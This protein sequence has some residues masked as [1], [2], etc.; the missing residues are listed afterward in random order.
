VPRHARRALIVAATVAPA[1]AAAASA[2]AATD[3][4]TGA[5]AKTDAEWRAALEPNAYRVLRRAWT[6]PPFTRHV[7]SGARRMRQCCS[8]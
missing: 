8:L 5:I 4:R 3:E 1:L 6:E 7:C 2:L